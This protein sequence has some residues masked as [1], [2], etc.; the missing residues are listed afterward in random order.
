MLQKCFLCIVCSHH[1]ANFLFQTRW[2]VFGGGE[3]SCSVVAL[4]ETLWPK[5]LGS[6][7]SQGAGVQ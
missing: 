6:A 1:H 7:G 3:T 2:R 4:A 5:Y